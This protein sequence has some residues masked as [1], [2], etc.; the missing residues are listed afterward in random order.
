MVDDLARGKLYFYWSMQI[1]LRHPSL[2]VAHFPTPE[3]C[4]TEVS[5]EDS[6]FLRNL[7]RA[8]VLSVQ[9]IAAA[10]GEFATPENSAWSN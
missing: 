8:I 5:Q 7:G 1:G 10:L 6:R 4:R 2:P 3:I 9:T